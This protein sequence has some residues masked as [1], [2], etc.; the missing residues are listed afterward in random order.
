MAC[1]QLWE[2]H[3]KSDHFRDNDET[4]I[5]CLEEW[6]KTAESDLQLAEALQ[7]NSLSPTQRLE[8]VFPATY[9]R[10][11]DGRIFLTRYASIFEATLYCFE[12]WKLKDNALTLK[13]WQIHNSLLMRLE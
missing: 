4:D 2:R 10:D 12:Y 6:A 5:E 7:G 9:S 11:A 3:K 13:V 1:V 8:E